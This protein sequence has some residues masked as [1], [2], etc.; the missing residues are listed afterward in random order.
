MKSR[1]KNTI[2]LDSATQ[3]TLLRSWKR[4]IEED[5]SLSYLVLQTS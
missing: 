1:A 4:K 2:A 3:C 5:R